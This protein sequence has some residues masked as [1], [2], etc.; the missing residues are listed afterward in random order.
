MILLTWNIQWCRGV[1]GRVDPRRIVDTARAI[2]DFDVLCL[3][4]VADNFPG[5]P[6]A[7]LDDQFACIA[8]LLPGYAAIEGVGVDRRDGA[9]GRRRRF[10]NLLLSRLPVLS[11]FRHLL[12]WPHDAQGIGM[13]RVAVEAVVEAAGGP[14]RVTTT[15]LEYYSQRQ[16]LAQV[17]RLR[18][19]QAEA[20]AHAADPPES[21]DAQGPFGV[22]PRPASA[23]LVGDFNFRVTDPEYE[24]IQ[25]PIGDR[26]PAYRDAW[27]IAHPGRPHDL[28]VGVFDRVQWP[29]PY[30]CDFA[31]VTEDLADRVEHVSVDLATDASDHQPIALRLRGR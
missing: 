8:A 14:V 4:E 13:Q 30:T 25:A 7:D 23:I 18:E 6:G 12:P 11:A 20:C 16:R 1:D 5:L 3:Q 9:D 17:A 10:G 19:L 22:A 15:H 24:R 21:H 31:F 29:Q 2:A 27:T 26:T 28:T